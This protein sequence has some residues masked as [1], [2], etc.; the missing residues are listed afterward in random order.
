[1]YRYREFVSIYVIYKITELTSIKLDLKRVQ[2]YVIHFWFESA[3]YNPI[4]HVV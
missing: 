3:R 1:M 2:K 4:L